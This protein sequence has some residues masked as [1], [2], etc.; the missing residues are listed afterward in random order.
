[1][2]SSRHTQIYEV[3][4]YFKHGTNLGDLPGFDWEVIG[5]IGMEYLK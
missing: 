5:E 3:G 4:K 1:M 2:E